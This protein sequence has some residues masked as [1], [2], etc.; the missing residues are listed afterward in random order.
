MRVLHVSPHPDDELLGC[1]ATLMALRDAGWDIVNYPVALGRPDDHDRRCA[2][3]TEA[4][5]RVRFELLRTQPL[6]IS[7][8]D[9]HIVA[10]QTLTDALSHLVGS[11]D[12][13]CSPS[14][15]DRH[16]GHE[17]V[18]RAVRRALEASDMPARW[19]MWSLW[20]DLPLP[21]VL[22]SFDR[23]RLH[24]I[25]HALEAH[26][27]ELERNDYRQIIRGRAQATAA[28]GVE[29]VFGFR[30]AAS[31]GEYAEVVCEAVR[32]DRRWFLGTAQNL[33]PDHPLISPSDIDLSFW[34]DT[35]S[36]TVHLRAH[37]NG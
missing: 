3:L 16:Y 2:E 9:D 4:C 19:W 32:R 36:V 8:G 6:A 21:T 15:H 34:L 28:L 17:V 30:A 27:G 1:P 10:E 20:G 31:G 11:Y 25:C 26:A 37:P 13:V 5:S 22:C 24:E 23:A 7:S 35:P 18:A 33:A 29:R 12:I 14:P